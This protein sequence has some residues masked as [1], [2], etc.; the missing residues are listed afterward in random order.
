MG[1]AFGLKRKLSKKDTPPIRPKPI[2]P[3]KGKNANL[4][5]D[6]RQVPV[7]VHHP[8]RRTKYIEISNIFLHFNKEIRIE[9]N[10]LQIKITGRELQ[11]HSILIPEKDA[12]VLDPH[13]LIPTYNRYVSNTSSHSQRAKPSS[14]LIFTLPMLV[15][16]DR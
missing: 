3:D 14:D 15:Y 16:V 12:T 9:W 7:K 6:V 1:L 11:V 13:T 5:P 10:L 4:L 2:N 8:G